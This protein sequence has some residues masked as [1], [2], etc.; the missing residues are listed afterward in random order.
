MTIDD[1]CVVL[2]STQ[3]KSTTELGEGRSDAFI[4]RESSFILLSRVHRNKWVYPLHAQLLTTEFQV[5]ARD[6]LT[7]SPNADHEA[8]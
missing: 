5:V 2:C 8:Q 6:S 7:G 3:G 4:S 1:P